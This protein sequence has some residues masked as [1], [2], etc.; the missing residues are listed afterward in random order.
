MSAGGREPLA[1]AQSEA[2]LWKKQ[3]EL[4][5]E[6]TQGEEAGPGRQVWGFGGIMLAGVFCYFSH[7]KEQVGVAPGEAGPGDAQVTGGRRLQQV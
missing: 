5:L 4:C 7:G 6:D 3:G 1:W 2:A